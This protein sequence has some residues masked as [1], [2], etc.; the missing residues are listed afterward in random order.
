M[1]EDEVIKELH[2]VKDEIAARFNYDVTAMGRAM[3][4]AD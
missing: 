1:H 2:R 3:Q 4:E